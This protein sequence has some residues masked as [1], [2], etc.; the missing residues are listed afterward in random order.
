MDNLKNKH[1]FLESSHISL[2]GQIF[3]YCFK[4]S[5]LYLMISENTYC[6]WSG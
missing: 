5:V 4:K 1:S 2:K 6:Y 3:G